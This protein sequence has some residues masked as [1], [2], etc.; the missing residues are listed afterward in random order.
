L[1]ELLTGILFIAVYQLEM[2]VEFWAP[3]DGF[4]IYSPDGPQNITTRLD[5]PA[6]LHLRY[7]LHMAM[8]C[9]LI[10][11]TFIDLELKII[12][13]GCTVPMLIIAVLAHWA[14]GQ[15]YL[16]PLWFQDES[17]VNATRTIAPE[18]MRGMLF[19]WDCMA[20]AI[21]HPHIHGLLVSLA[22]IIGGAAVVWVVRVFGTFVLKQEAMGQGDVILMAMVGSVIGWQPVVAAFFLAPLL[23]ISAAVYAWLR[24]RG[25]E[26]PYGPWLSLATVLVLMFWSALWPFAER[27][28]DMGP[29]LA[30]LAVFMLVSLLASLYLVQFGKRLLGMPTGPEPIPEDGGWTSA[31]H[32][33]YYNSECTDQQVGQWPTPLWQGVRAG[34][35]RSTYHTWR[36]GR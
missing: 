17:V 36:Y 34:Q 16:V 18:W 3:V 12:P 15:L 29:F 31:D 20:F 4:G 35:G 6:W 9:C 8:I 7:A 27:V 2:P 10:V 32:L 19:S 25:R 24:K 26:L 22:G 5:V 14:S 1:V 23:A 13:D 33:Q 21:K 30:V 28:F 11:A